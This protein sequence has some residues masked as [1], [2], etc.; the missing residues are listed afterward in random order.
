MSLQTQKTIKNHKQTSTTQ[1]NHKNTTTQLFYKIQNSLPWE[2][3][4]PPSEQQKL[5]EGLQVKSLCY[6]VLYLTK[7]GPKATTKVHLFGISVEFLIICHPSNNH[8][9]N[10]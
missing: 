1:Q 7:F 6:F 9:I 8:C 5:V 2:S 3:T 4:F 10:S